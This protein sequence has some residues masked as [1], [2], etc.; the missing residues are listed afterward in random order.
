MP[1]RQRS[2]R[3]ADVG[4]RVIAHPQCEQFQEFASQVFVRCAALIRHAVEPAEQGRVAQHGQVQFAYL[5]SPQ[6][7][8]FFV[9]LDQVRFFVNPFLAR[10]VV[11]VPGDDH[12]LAQRPGG[13]DHAIEPGHANRVESRVAAAI[14]FEH[15]VAERVD[16]GRRAAVGSR[17]RTTEHARDGGFIAVGQ[18]ALGLGPGSAET[19][20]TMHPQH[21]GQIPRILALG[22]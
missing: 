15:G 18:I 9:L 20:P 12:P 22:S 6:F 14:R 21:L 13:E 1:A 3:F 8:L 16:R 7:A 5:A 2:G 17:R 4:F 11:R 19:G 10:G